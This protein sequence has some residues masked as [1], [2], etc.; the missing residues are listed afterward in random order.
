MGRKP[1]LWAEDVAV[2][3][4]ATGDEHLMEMV[5]G[6]LSAQRQLS[7]DS[8]FDGAPPSEL[9]VRGH[10]SIR[11]LPPE[12]RDAPRNLP[13]DWRIFRAIL[14]ASEVQEFAPG[15]YKEKEVRKRWPAGWQTGRSAAKPGPRPKLSDANAAFELGRWLLQHEP[16]SREELAHNTTRIL[17]PALDERGDVQVPTSRNFARILRMA[18]ASAER[19]IQN[20]LRYDQIGLDDAEKMLARIKAWRD[21]KMPGRKSKK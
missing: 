21:G 6:T 20:A 3:W 7:K 16:T 18:F 4:I 5:D 8:K 2:A 9:A 19:E 15:Q 12:Y 17:A 1:N 14:M 11:V 13:P 10:F